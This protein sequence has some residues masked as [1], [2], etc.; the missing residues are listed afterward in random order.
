MKI[1][2]KCNTKITTQVLLKEQLCKLDIPFSYD[3][4]GD[5]EINGSLSQNQKD[6][7]IKG[8]QNYGLTLLEDPKMGL[9][10]RIKTTIDEMFEDDDARK[11]NVSAYLADKLSYTYAHISSVFSESTFTSIENYVILRKVDLA[12]DL[13]NKTDLTLTEI[14]DRLHYSSVAH[15]S[16]QFKRTTGL[17]PSTFQRIMQRKG[18]LTN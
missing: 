14:A 17:T 2:L 16:A 1:N 3:T 12:K 18:V 5:V 8:L 9:V 15:L 4:N 7:L 6:A 11:M 13:L 10:E